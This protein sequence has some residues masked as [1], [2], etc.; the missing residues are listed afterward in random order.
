MGSKNILFYDF[1]IKTPQFP[2]KIA[3]KQVLKSL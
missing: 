3:K 1:M 2:L